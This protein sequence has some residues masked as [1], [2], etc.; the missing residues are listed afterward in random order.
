MQHISAADFAFYLENVCLRWNDFLW[1]QSKRQFC[2]FLPMGSGHPVWEKLIAP[3]L[4]SPQRGH[5][6]WFGQDDP[7][8]PTNEGSH[9]DWRPSCQ[10]SLDIRLAAPL[11]DHIQALQ[12]IAL[13]P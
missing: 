12:S 9:G 11:P 13:S 3:Q 7:Q 4:P 2:V 5:T 10:L 8:S 6:S 1:E